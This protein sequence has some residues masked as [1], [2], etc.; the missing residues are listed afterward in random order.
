MKRTQFLLT[1]LLSSSILVA[2][3]RSPDGDSVP[4]TTT[5]PPPATTPV[6]PTDKP[7]VYMM[8]VPPGAQGNA[9]TSAQGQQPPPN[10]IDQLHLYEELAFAPVGLTG[11]AASCT[12]PKDEATFASNIST[13]AGSRDAC[14]YFKASQL[15]APADATCSTRTNPRTNGTVEI[16][17]D[18]WGV[19][20]VKADTREDAMY[21]FGYAGAAVRLWLFDVL[22]YIGRGRLSAFLGPA[23]DTRNFDKDIAAVTGY[24]E[25]EV[26]R[27]L[28][29]TGGKW[30]L[31]VTDSQW[32]SASKQAT[33]AL[34][35]ANHVCNPNSQPIGRD[36]VTYPDPNDDPAYGKF[37]LLSKMVVCDLDAMVAGMNAFIASDLNG[38]PATLATQADYALTVTATQPSGKVPMCASATDCSAGTGFTRNDIVASAILIQSIFAFGGGG[39]RNNVH[40]IQHFDNSFGGNDLTM[41]QRACEYWR[42]LRH[43]NDVTTP[44]TDASNAVNARQSPATI[45]TSCTAAWPAGHASLPSGTAIWDAGSYQGRQIFKNTVVAS[46]PSASLLKPNDDKAMKVAKTEIPESLTGLF[47]L[48][49]DKRGKFVASLRQ[50]FAAL[51]KNKTLRKALASQKPV[52]T[53]ARVADDPYTAAHTSLTKAGFPVPRTMSNF[54]GVTGDQT[55]DGQPIAVM[56]PQTGYFVPQLLWEISIQSGGNNPDPFD[57]AGRGVVFG[58]LPYVNIGRGIDF[59][60]SATSG[61]TDLVDTRVS[62]VCLLASGALNTPLLGVPSADDNFNNATGVAGADGFPDFDGYLFDADDGNGMQCRPVITRR[63]QFTAEGAVASAA[64]GSTSL[65]ENIEIFVMRTHYGPIIATATLNGDIVA[66][67]TERSTFYAE[68]D[69]APGFALA[70]TRVIGNSGQGD[71][72]VQDFYEIFNGVTGTFNWQYIQKDNLAWFHSGLF[73]NRDASAHPELPVWGDGRAD[74]PG[75]KVDLSVDTDFFNRNYYPNLAKPRPQ[76]TITSSTVLPGAAVPVFFEYDNFRQLADHPRVNNPPVGYLHSWNNA[77]ASGWWAADGNG[78]YGPM[79]RASMLL[80]RLQAYQ[81]TGKK[82]TLGSMV[83]I[84]SDAAHTDLMGMKL[85]PLLIEALNTTPAGQDFSSLPGIQD[86]AQLDEMIAFLKTWSDDGSMKWIADANSNGLG[87]YRRTKRDG[88]QPRARTDSD[89][90]DVEFEYLYRNQVVLMDTFYPHLADHIL[91]QFREIDASAPTLTGFHN[92]P[93]SGGSAY[94]NG[95]YFIMFRTLS[96]A[97]DAELGGNRSQGGSYNRIACAATTNAENPSFADCRDGILTALSDAVSQ[98]GGWSTR[99]TWDGTQNGGTRTVEN[100][101]AIRHTPL[102]AQSMDAMHWS[103]RP[104]FQ[105]V[106][107]IFKDRNDNN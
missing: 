88:T 94:Q 10:F 62:K 45:P 53:I 5:T 93:G 89:N 58:Q 96:N 43:A 90:A 31:P 67:S 104:T 80:D 14:N 75:K 25:E 32:A 28:E 101:D 1:A 55:A 27:I 4:S 98:L 82:H 18:G 13:P 33:I 7:D 86:R 59:A 60:W 85:V 91:Q 40:A 68:L 35:D 78:S 95:W 76:K 69:T 61:N 3:G 21:G 49:V 23:N 9:G 6:T 66:V 73:P 34:N 47:Q 57:F 99:S 84:M 46:A 71:A 8:V 29:F 107:Q 36:A 63:D 50:Q 38:A 20:Y 2:C 12:P 83:E 41:S 54:I 48:S 92:R 17:F 97:L 37:G 16:C 44:K 52:S 24:N 74:W 42:D 22:R 87:G 103:N 81:A 51:A 64:L 105:G 65:Q 77:P 79:H 15:D 100:R 72:Q 102:S 19:P 30:P 26:T 11:D 106:F 70:T 39:E 56:G